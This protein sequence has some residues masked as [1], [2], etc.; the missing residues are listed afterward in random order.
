MFVKTRKFVKDNSHTLAFAAGS[1]TTSTVFY[2]LT[3][4]KTLLELNKMQLEALKQGVSVVYTLKDQTLHLVNI[5]AIEAAQ[6][7]L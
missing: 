6:A 7:A 5:P 4:D 3:K 1:I 2:F